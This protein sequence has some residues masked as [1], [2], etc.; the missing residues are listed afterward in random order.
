[1]QWLGLSGR[2]TPWHPNIDRGLTAVHACLEGSFW[3][4]SGLNKYAFIS[5]L[6]SRSRFQPWG[7]GMWNKGYVAWLAAFLFWSDYF[8]TSK[9]PTRGYDCLSLYIHSIYL[10]KCTQIQQS[11]S[12]K[13]QNLCLSTLNMLPLG[14]G[15]HSAMLYT[16]GCKRR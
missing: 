8:A 1:M 14:W 10:Y 5:S 11:F 13:I 16:H 4:L 6:P 12:H 7:D 2:N 9:Y 3:T 15:L